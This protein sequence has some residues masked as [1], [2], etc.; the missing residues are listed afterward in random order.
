MAAFFSKLCRGIQR[1]PNLLRGQN[2]Y[3]NPDKL[4]LID[5]AF[6][7]ATRGA[8]SFADLGGVWKVNGAYAV[9]A[10]THYP[11]ERGFIVDTDFTEKA[12]AGIYRLGNL[13]RIVGDFGRPEVV[14]R[15]G[16]ADIVFFFDVLLHQVAPDWDEV[17]RRY[18]EISRCFVIYNQQY[19]GGPKTI[20][21]TDLPLERY[22]ELVPRRSDGLYE[23]VYANKSIKHPIYGKLWKDVHNIWQWGI[24]TGDLRAT[25]KSLGWRE[26]YFESFGQYPALDAFENQGFIYVKP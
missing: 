25:M 20:R 19:V 15:I 12:N 8:Q 26:A 16:R 9:Y 5:R 21:L 10:A 17:L 24:T 14:Q 3:V 11:V 4:R 1:L 6:T 18:A 13:Q 7:N 23:F 2:L 22:T